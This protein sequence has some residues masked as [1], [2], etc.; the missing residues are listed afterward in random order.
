MKVKG[1]TN[2]HYFQQ[3]NVCLLEFL[4]MF[5]ILE[6]EELA[7]KKK[8]VFLVKKKKLE[9]SKYEKKKSTFLKKN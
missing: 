3:E 8:I 6:M 7:R 5:R 2:L 4:R 9:T 1:S